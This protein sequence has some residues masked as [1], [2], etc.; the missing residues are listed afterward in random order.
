MAEVIGTVSPFPDWDGQES[1]MDTFKRMKARLNEI[2]RTQELDWEAGEIVGAVISVPRGD[3]HAMYYVYKKDPL[4]LL[5]IPWVDKWHADPIWIKGL[6]VEDVQDMIRKSQ[7][8]VNY[9]AKK[10]LE[11]A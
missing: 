10:E 8:W 2:D 7:A 1:F 11:N 5:W 9:M 4:Q 6:D 3:G